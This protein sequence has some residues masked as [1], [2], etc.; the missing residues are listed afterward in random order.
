MKAQ[1]QNEQV[2][3]ISKLAHLNWL[4]WGNIVFAFLFWPVTVISVIYIAVALTR[5]KTSGAPL[6]KATKDYVIGIIVMNSIALL[7]VGGI[8][9]IT[10][11]LVRQGQRVHRTDLAIESL[12]QIYQQEKEFRQANS[13]FGTLS[14]MQQ[15]SADRAVSAKSING[16]EIRLSNLNTNSYCVEAVRVED[17][18]GTGDF[19]LCEDGEL[20][21]RHSF[22]K[23]SLQRGEGTSIKCL[24]PSPACPLPT[25]GP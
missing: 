17:S 22:S 18:S 8:L 21:I 2:F 19:I 13:R 11:G 7:I 12:R 20:R 16:Y 23:N 1:P 9:I 10:I 15:L 25:P 3:D 14:E 6:N 5:M 4:S 24:H